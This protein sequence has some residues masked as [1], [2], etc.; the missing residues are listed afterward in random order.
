HK[1]K[2]RP[3]FTSEI[4]DDGQNRARTT[5]VLA[6]RRPNSIANPIRDVQLG[7]YPEDLATWFGRW[8]RNLAEIVGPARFHTS[9]AYRVSRSRPTVADPI[10]ELFGPRLG[11]HH[12]LLSSARTTRVSCAVLCNPAEYLAA[13]GGVT[14]SRDKCE[15]RSASAL[16]I[17]QAQS[18]W[19]R[20]RTAKQ[21][22]AR[23]GGA[24]GGRRGHT[25]KTTTQQNAQTKTSTSTPH[26]TVS[27][28]FYSI[29][30]RPAKCAVPPP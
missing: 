3:D 16:S 8:A 6:R 20:I 15:D 4:R 11:F 22:H 27:P 18:I 26:R 25:C 9:F 1:Y 12:L 21:G 5:L 30:T 2:K 10:I 14:Y 19:T 7:P 23:V 29:P 28:S 24:S 13:P 17:Q